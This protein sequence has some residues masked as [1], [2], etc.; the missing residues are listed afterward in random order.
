MPKISVIVP[1]YNAERTLEKCITSIIDQEIKDIEIILVNDGSTDDSFNICNNLV[2]KYKQIK[3]ISGRNEGVSV[4]RNKGINIAKGEYIAF[5][6]ADDIVLPKIYSNMLYI[7]EKNKLELVFCNFYYCYSDNIWKKNH[8]LDFTEKS[9]INSDYIIRNILRISNRN[10]SATCWRLLVNKDMLVKKGIKFPSGI[11]MAE[12]FQFVLNCLSSVELVGLCHECLYCLNR[13]N[14][15]TTTNYMKN[16]END[17]E[18]INKWLI[19]FVQNN[20]TTNDIDIKIG[21]YSS[22][23]NTVVSNIENLC[24]KG[25]PFN[26]IERIFNS[27]RI[28]SKKIYIDAIKK[29]LHYPS[30]CNKKKFIQ[31]VFIRVHL[32]FLIVL[33]FTIRYKTF[34]I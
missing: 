7:A 24:K 32:N 5:V 13:V 20:F 12:D 25:T 29:I 1:I 21:L 15:T 2:K 23:A 19:E 17:Q 16:K 14:E 31:F 4:A 9:I 18:I 26:I 11:T 3:I 33:Y 22:L 27:Y 30:A 8:S 28:A 10:I 6:D 34:K